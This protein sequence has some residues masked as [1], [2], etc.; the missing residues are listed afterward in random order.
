[1]SIVLPFWPSWGQADKALPCPQHPTIG[2]LIS[3]IGSEDLVEEAA[4]IR[5]EG[6]RLRSLP[7]PGSLLAPAL[8]ESL[9]EKG[10]VSTPLWSGQVRTVSS[11]THRLLTRDNQSKKQ[12]QGPEQHHSGLKIQT[13]EETLEGQ[14]CLSGPPRCQVSCS[15]IAGQA[16]LLGLPDFSP[17]HPW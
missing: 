15:N 14:T 5:N 6:Q 7:F 9:S 8:H 3:H 4:K 2:Q 12:H 10:Q 11:P 16:G 13:A 17:S 1:M